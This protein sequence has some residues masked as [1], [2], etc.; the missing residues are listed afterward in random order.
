ME[1]VLDGR[2]AGSSDEPE[3]VAGLQ[4]R[5]HQLEQQLAVLDRHLALS[6]AEQAERARLKKEK[7]LVKDRILVLTAAKRPH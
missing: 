2:E 7:L 5:H 4:R 3:E 1:K 6:A